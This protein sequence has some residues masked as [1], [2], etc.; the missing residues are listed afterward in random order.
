MRCSWRCCG[1]RRVDDEQVSLRVRLGSKHTVT[2]PLV[3]IACICNEHDSDI[4]VCTTF[5]SFWDIQLGVCR[6]LWSHSSAL[7][8]PMVGATAETF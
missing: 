2:T 1:G 7:S 5:T 3:D 6:P 8:S 4:A